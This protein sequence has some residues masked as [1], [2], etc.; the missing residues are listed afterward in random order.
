[1]GRFSSL[2]RIQQEAE[3][4]SAYR[5]STTT[6]TLSQRAPGMGAISGVSGAT[7]PF[8]TEIAT[9]QAE[10]QYRHFRGWVYT[11][12]KTI[13]NR[14]A[15]QTFAM[16]RKLN[17]KKPTKGHK[18][19]QP[20]TRELVATHV[21]GHLL[22]TEVEVVQDHELLQALRSPQDAFVAW[23]LFYLTASN[24][25]LT[26]RSFWW[27]QRENGRLVGVWPLPSHWVKT[28]FTENGKLV[29]YE[30]K[31]PDSPAKP[32]P[33]SKEDMVSF[34]FPNP[35]DPLSAVSP[36][37]TQATAVAVDEAI[38]TAQYRAFKNGIFPGVLLRVGKFEGIGGMP[39]ELPLLDAAQRRDLVAAVQ[40]LYGGVLNYGDPL[41]LDALIEGVEKLTHAPQEMD[42]LD[43]G[44]AVKKR[45][46]QAFGVNPILTGQ[47]DGANRAQ[48][49]V[50]DGIFA[51]SVVNPMADMIG[52]VLSAWVANYSKGSKDLMFWIEP[53]RPN[54][55][56][57]KLKEW[58]GGMTQ[59]VVT[60]DEYRQNVLGLGAMTEED[61]KQMKELMALRIMGKP[62]ASGNTSGGTG[63]TPASDSGN[64]R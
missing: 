13:A 56:E 5:L 16:G 20:G 52:Q 7:R 51:A 27:M 3:T 34:L 22:A 6:A 32:I 21:R 25:M 61:K 49:A 2:S 46:F 45:I 11:A 62:N 18:L 30:V 53:A 60:P 40:A 48:A 63:R 10:E 24:L 8:E 58:L 29:G 14:L 59:L 50:A 38:Q 64:Q 43:S 39:G 33:V 26:G 15:G 37:Q 4:A 41:I 9:I 19:Y 31:R 44:E 36:L 23:T 57:L 17:G 54:D 1:M 42:F 35:G 28:L 55:D 12:I 47:T